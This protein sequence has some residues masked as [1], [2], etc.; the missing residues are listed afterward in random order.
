MRNNNKLPT[1]REEC[2]K[3]LGEKMRADYKKRRSLIFDM[4][5]TIIDRGKAGDFDP[6]VELVK[7]YSKKVRLFTMYEGWNDVFSFI[8]DKCLTVTIVS[9]ASETI[10]KTVMSYFDIPYSY[11]VIYV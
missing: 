3:L 9:D 5:L 8:R 6:T 1:T 11:I 10:I 4:D 7:D 2:L